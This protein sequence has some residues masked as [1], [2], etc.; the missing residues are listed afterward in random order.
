[1][2]ITILY[3]HV[4]SA[5]AADEQDVLSQVEVVRDALLALGHDTDEIA[6][7]LDLSRLLAKL[8]RRPPDVAFNLVESLGGSDRL[9]LAVP[10]LLEARGVPFTGAPLEALLRTTNKVVAKE[11]LERLEIAT[12]R[13]ADIHGPLVVGPSRRVIVKSRWTHGSV[14]IEDDAVIDAIDERTIRDRLAA[15]PDDLFVEEFIEGREFNLSV[16]GGSAGPSVLP[17]A[18]IQFTDFGTDRP[19]IVGFRAKWEP[20]SPEYEG[21]PR[22]F[23]FVAADAPLLAALRDAALRAYLGT[24]VRGYARV[25]FRVPVD[26]APRVLE[27][28]ANPCLSPD[29]GF[30]AAASR[31]GLRFEEVVERILQD[32]VAETVR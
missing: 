16:L 6:V 20:G 9:I 4:D 13:W 27:V 15:A 32:A 18:E 21:T 10:A 7:S 3:N 29:A 5:A 17:P 23:D 1:M 12:P 30:L 11:F 25:D 28:N 8:E 19:H 22:T 14:G 31:E 26:G 2:R 24:N